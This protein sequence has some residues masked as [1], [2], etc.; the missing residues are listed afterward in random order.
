MLK[1]NYLMKNKFLNLNHVTKNLR[2]FINYYK[3]H[4]QKLGLSFWFRVMHSRPYY[5][6]RDCNL[7]ENFNKL[8]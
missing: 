8:L 7:Y 4:H 6:S 5:G 2:I 3:N 1:I